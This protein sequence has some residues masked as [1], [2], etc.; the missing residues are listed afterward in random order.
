MSR[1]IRAKFVCE[2]IKVTS[3]SRNQNEGEEE[4][5][6]GEYFT[7]NITWRAS[8]GEGKDNKDWSVWTPSGHLQMNID[9]P[10]A[11]GHFKPGREYY[12]DL[13]EVED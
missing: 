1:T 12:L 4:P 10:G 13:I 8:Y 6:D 2:D 7:E 5:E 11:Q 9:N 3:R